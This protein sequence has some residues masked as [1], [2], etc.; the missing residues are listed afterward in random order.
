[1]VLKRFF[2]F[3]VILLFA[4]SFASAGFFDFFKGGKVTGN[5]VS[6]KKSCVDSDGNL[7]L[8][9]SKFIKGTTTVKKDNIIIREK[10][11]SCIN[12]KK[13]KEYYCGINKVTLKSKKFDCVNGCV[14]GA[15]KSL[16]SPIPEQTY[17]NI[18]IF[19]KDN[20]VAVSFV[21]DVMFSRGKKE[22]YILSYARDTNSLDLLSK[23]IL[24]DSN[25]YTIHVQEG[26]NI[27]VSE[28][29]I[30]NAGDKGRILRLFDIGDP[31]FITSKTVFID[32]ISGE[33]FEFST[34]IANKSSRTIDGQTYYV[35]TSGSTYGS[36]N[37]T[38]G[39]GAAP[40][41]PGTQ[42]TLFPRIKLKNGEWMSILTS[43]VVNN[44]T[45]YVLPGDNLELGS[46]LSAP[47]SSSPFFFINLFSTFTGIGKLG[48]WV[49][50]WTYINASNNNKP[51]NGTLKSVVLNTSSSF[52][53][54]DFSFG[55][56]ILIQEGNGEY[57]CFSLYKGGIGNTASISHPK[58]SDMEFSGFPALST[59]G[60]MIEGRDN[61]RGD[62][63]GKLLTILY[64]KK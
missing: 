36:V 10:I 15:C 58:F 47:F 20:F 52:N 13:L 25:N 9:N 1:M 50:N 62:F 18:T 30:I 60:T 49:D 17:D 32:V 23:L 54:C 21:T 33:S 4:F 24:A 19:T 14:D 34:G 59:Y 16:Q 31:T 64:P 38:W 53:Y 41:N 44:N 6:L 46:N 42:T 2:V 28:K 40:G 63:T 29:V 8:E 35:S 5:A 37:L 55:P 27:N 43:T 56:V 3:S 51:V 61:I 48:Y 39:A 11:D 26:E 57:I 12:D 45:K 7:S 22:P